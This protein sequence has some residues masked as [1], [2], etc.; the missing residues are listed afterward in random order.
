MKQGAILK[1]QVTLQAGLKAGGAPL[2]WK[3]VMGDVLPMIK[4]LVP[5]E[6]R[7]LEVGYGDGLLTCYLCQDL[8]WYI[9]GLDVS[10]GAYDK[11][12]LN[13]RRYG[14]SGNIEFRCCNP[15]ETKKHCGQYDA[16]FIKTVLYSSP[17]LD[18]YASWLDWVISV[19]K[20]GGVLI[21]FETGRANA[22]MQSYRKIRGRSYTDLC[23]YTRKVETLYDSRFEIINRYYYGGMSQFLAPSRPLYFIASRIEETLR[24]R[25]AD[26][27]FIVTI[28]A[29]KRANSKKFEE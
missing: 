11:A 17:N 24:S 7:V 29:R 14:L 28:I 26:N 20:P 9:M 18:D 2:M 22:L 12:M 5:A 15:D 6:S 13:A 10:M 25:H 19:L 16:V 21:N 8:G 27:S 4:E 1:D 23:L 3:R